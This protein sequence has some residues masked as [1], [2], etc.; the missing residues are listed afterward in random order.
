ME[1]LKELKL[2]LTQ[3]F[4]NIYSG[5]EYRII[6]NLGMVEHKRDGISFHYRG[7]TVTLF[8]P[9]VDGLEQL[10]TTSYRELFLTKLYSWLDVDGKI[11]FDIGA[12][13]GDSAIFFSLN[14]AKK[15]ISLEPYP[16]YFDAMK[17]NILANKLTN[18]VIMLN[19]GIGKKKIRLTRGK[20]PLGDELSA[21]K[22]GT[23]VRLVGLDELLG[24]FAKENNDAVLKLDCEGGEYYAIMHSDVNTLRRFDQIV[25]E[26]H[27]GV[28]GLV[29][30]LERSGFYV[31]VERNRVYPN[32]GYIR[33]KINK[34]ETVLR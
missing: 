26:Y 22:G 28:L 31:R 11:V 30:K 27:R 24:R 29:K 33:A 10:P 16:A 3:P 14:G 32:A 21:V 34:N 13:V 4:R 18:K 5:W 2:Y 1:I 23:E 25:I 12:N 9:Q 17:R 15:V 19:E 6:N 20:P 7:K 8:R